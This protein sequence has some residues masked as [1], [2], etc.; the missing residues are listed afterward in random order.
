MLAFTLSG[1]E[2]QKK[3]KNNKHNIVS[4]KVEPN[5]HNNSY[6]YHNYN[7]IPRHSQQRVMYASNHSCKNNHVYTHR[8]PQPHNSHLRVTLPKGFVAMHINGEKYFVNNGQFFRHIKNRGF[9]LVERP[10]H[11]KTLPAGAI[12]VRIN[13]DFYFRYHNIYFKWTPFGYRVV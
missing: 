3:G 12:K 4:V 1:V 6:S 11:I 5:R 2:A 10:H 9:V 13:G 8:I 7:Y